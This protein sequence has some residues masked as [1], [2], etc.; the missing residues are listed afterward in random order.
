[1]E[2]EKEIV[3]YLNIMGNVYLNSNY[4]LSMVNTMKGEVCITTRSMLSTL[5]APYG[6]IGLA[7]ILL[8][9]F[10]YGGIDGAIAILLTMVV[11]SAV[12]ILGVIPIFGVLIY[13][14]LGYYHILPYIID[15]TPIEG[16]DWIMWTLFILAG[17]LAL[18]LTYDSTMRLVQK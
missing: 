9:Y 7:L 10:V 1:M 16:M 6:V 15:V 12:A 8:A 18:S 2:E 4:F 5:L 3:R 13:G 11:L 17:L 14:Y